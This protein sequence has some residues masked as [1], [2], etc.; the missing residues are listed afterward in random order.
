MAL[1]VI[2][3]SGT[4]FDFVTLE[5]VLVREDGVASFKSLSACVGVA[6]A[7]EGKCS[8]NDIFGL[9]RGRSAGFNGEARNGEGTLVGENWSFSY[10]GGEDCDWERGGVCS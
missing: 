5:G 2:T 4:S 1:S 3:T 6:G 10:R 7:S 9:G 8:F